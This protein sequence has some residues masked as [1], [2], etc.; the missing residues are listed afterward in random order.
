MSLIS[1]WMNREKSPSK[2]RP[3]EQDNE[4]N[5]DIL[6]RS[7]NNLKSLEEIAAIL[8][9]GLL[10]INLSINQLCSPSG[11]PNTIKKLNLSMNR[12]TSL[13]GFNCFPNC[14]WL[15]ISLNELTSFEGIDLPNLTY[16]NATSNSLT[17]VKGI[18]RCRNVSTL[19][20]NKNKL[21]TITFSASN[22]NVSRM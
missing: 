12:F 4:V 9:K 16:L 11:L 21:K 5:L 6:D 1:D 20:L 13:R 8:R 2:S 15:D 19:I 18:E 14:T 17:K 22:V 7:Q 3:G 10:E